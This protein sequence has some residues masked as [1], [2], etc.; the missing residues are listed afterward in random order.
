MQSEREKWLA[1]TCNGPILVTDYAA[2]LKP[3]YMRSKYYEK[4]VACLD[5]LTPGIGELVGGSIREEQL[6]FLDEA[7]KRN[8]TRCGSDLIAFLN[9][10]DPPGGVS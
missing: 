4:A 9:S 2:S 7:L 1:E 3:F 6:D 8:T 5:L 10:M